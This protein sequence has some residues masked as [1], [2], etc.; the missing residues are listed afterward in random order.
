MQ[1]ELSGTCPTL[2]FSVG[3]RAMIIKDTDGDWAIVVGRWDEFRK[4]VPAVKGTRYISHIS[5]AT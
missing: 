2:D 1:L 3:E 5:T 4:G